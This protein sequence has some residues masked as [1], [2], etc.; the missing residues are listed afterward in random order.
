MKILE[1]EALDFF[2]RL[3]N[4]LDERRSI[5]DETPFLW[6]FQNVSLEIDEFNCPDYRYLCFAKRYYCIYSL[7]LGS[8][9]KELEFSFL[10]DLYNK[11]KVIPFYYR[12]FKKEL[13]ANE[14]GVFNQPRQEQVARQAERFLKMAENALKEYDI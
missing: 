8:G 11:N 9:K 5:Y 3:I 1:N 6:R 12:Y 7:I 2:L 4:F 14:S 13:S 10:V